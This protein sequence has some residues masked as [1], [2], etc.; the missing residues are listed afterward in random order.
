MK[1]LAGGRELRGIHQGGEQPQWSL[2]PDCE[3]VASFGPVLGS[4][5]TGGADITRTLAPT[6]PGTCTITATILGLSATK[7]VTIK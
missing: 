3:G 6:K 1:P 4:Q 2:G 7:T 5:D